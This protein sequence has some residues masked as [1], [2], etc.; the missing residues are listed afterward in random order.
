MLL[1]HRPRLLFQHLPYSQQEKLQ[2]SDKEVAVV[3]EGV[4]G[5]ADG[6]SFW[7]VCCLP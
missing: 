4:L 2:L 3:V 7:A 6:Q 5:I 1:S